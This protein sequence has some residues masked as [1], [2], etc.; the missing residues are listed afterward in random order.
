MRSFLRSVLALFALGG[1][2]V[3]CKEASNSSPSSEKPRKTRE[4]QSTV[5]FYV[6]DLN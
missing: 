3:G 6:A 4:G 5:T 2:T 1:S